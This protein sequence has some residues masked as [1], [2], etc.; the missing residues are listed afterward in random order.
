MYIWNLLSCNL[1]PLNLVLLLKATENK[2][3][4]P[5][6]IWRSLSYPLSVF[7][8]LKR[9]CSLNL[10]L[11]GFSSLII[12]IAPQQPCAYLGGKQ[13]LLLAL[14][15]LGLQSNPVQF[16]PES[17]HQ[18][19]IQDWKTLQMILG[20]FLVL[21]WSRGYHVLS[22][23]ICFFSWNDLLGRSSL[24]SA[25]LQSI[26]FIACDLSCFLKLSVFYGFWIHPFYICGCHFTTAAFVHVQG[27]L[28]LAPAALVAQNLPLYSAGLH[29]IPIP[30]NYPTS[31]HQ[32][33]SSKSCPSTRMPFSVW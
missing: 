4:I 3:V 16:V 2:L 28:P 8:R 22:R 14:L 31:F 21:E 15:A 27:L 11:Q 12:L 33:L 1:Y 9:S 7:S 19:T 13:I 26:N 30:W 6:G 17:I 5:S 20:V 32:V 18:L 25:I 24:F 29:P 23:E 10:S